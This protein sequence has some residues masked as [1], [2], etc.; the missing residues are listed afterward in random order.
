MRS[1][2]GRHLRFGRHAGFHGRVEHLDRIGGAVDDHIGLGVIENLDADGVVVT[3]DLE[4]VFF[5]KIRLFNSAPSSGSG[6]QSRFRRSHRSGPPRRG[7]HARGG[8]RISDGLRS[9]L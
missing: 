2:N 8:K 4:I 9:A 6:P 7:R 1:G 5:H 3:V